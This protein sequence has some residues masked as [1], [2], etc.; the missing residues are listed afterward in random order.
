M[1]EATETPVETPEAPET[2]P[3]PDDKANSTIRQMRS[4]MDALAQENKALKDAQTAQER[5]KM[6]ELERVKA[7]KADAEAKAAEADRLRDE[8]GRY[9]SRD[10]ERYERELASVPEEHKA[11]LERLSGAG[12]SWGDKYDLLQEAKALLPGPAKAGSVTQPGF[13]PAGGEGGGKPALDPKN[14]SWAGAF[15]KPVAP[16]DKV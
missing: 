13:P 7:E 9:Q 4:Q 16:V 10:Q 11:R 14:T 1:S 3:K 8:L 2:T 6:D 15:S 12:A 5:A